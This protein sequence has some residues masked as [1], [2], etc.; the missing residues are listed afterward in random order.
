MWRIGVDI[1]QTIFDGW[2]RRSHLDAAWARYRETQGIYL[3]TV[4]AAFQ[5]TEDALNNVDQQKREWQKLDKAY[6]AAEIRASLSEKQYGKGIANLLEVIENRRV[7]IEA[8]RKQMNVLGLQYQS[9][10]QL[11]K[12]LGGD[13]QV[14][15]DLLEPSSEENPCSR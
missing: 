4:L 14:H 7:E 15:E 2:K 10:V 12:A 11:I 6:E 9:T 3:K 8:L 5:E 13:W 1:V